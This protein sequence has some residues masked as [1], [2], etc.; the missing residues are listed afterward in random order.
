MKPT[1]F[2]AHLTRFLAEYLPAQRSVSPNTVK[3]YRD[4]FMLLLRFYRDRQGL[5]PERVTLG[6]IDV[7]RVLAFLGH[8]ERE[9]RCGIRTRNHRLS[10]L[11]AFFRYLQTEEPGRIMQCQQIL[12]I[13]FQRFQ[14]AEVSYL[15]PDELAAI[16]AQPDLNTS[17]G[18]RD[19]VLLSLLYDTGARVQELVDIKVRDIRLES[20]AQVLLHGKGKKTRIVPLLS[21]TVNL[22]AEYIHEHRL[23]RPDL[24][25]L[26]LFQNRHRTKLSRS[27]VSYVLAKYALQANNRQSGS[28]RHISPHTFRHTKAM[29]LLQ[30]GNPMTTIQAILGHA[31]LKTSAIYATADLEMKRAALEKAAS[32]APSPTLP[33]WRQDTS[34]MEW[35][36]KL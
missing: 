14:R 17:E 8:L 23:D 22:L 12:A 34:L 21:G 1:D 3:S 31:D 16:L 5:N 24:Q 18:R 7:N 10:A 27:G 4:V 30:A 32:V 6:H 25:D 19:A 36:R 26:N 13:P 33:S 9:R 20:P 28:E 15:T 2:A 35:L 11:H 29:H